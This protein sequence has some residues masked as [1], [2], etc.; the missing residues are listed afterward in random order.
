MRHVAHKL[1]LRQLLLGYDS[2]LGRG[3]QGDITLLTELGQEL[4]YGVTRMS[5]VSQE[6]QVIS[7]SAIRKYLMAGAVEKAAAFL[8]RWYSLSGIII[9]GDG[10]GHTIHFPTA[11][12]DIPTE[13][14]I[15]SNGIYATN[16]WLY[17][18]RFAAATNVGTNPTFTPDKTTSNV[19]T[20]LLDFSGDLYG[21]EIRLEFVQHLR[22]EM[23]FSSVDALISQIRVDVDRA[24]QILFP[25][26]E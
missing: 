8:G 15:P 24:R 2:A 10:R 1:A 6:E 9:H 20:Y 26:V 16:V 21:R 5:P 12:L 17:G 7:S 25:P 4:G 23:K 22:D 11:N 18:E 13:K 3:R 19:E 14:L